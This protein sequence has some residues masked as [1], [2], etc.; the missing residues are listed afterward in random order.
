[1]AL[2]LLLPSLSA[3]QPYAMNARAL[4]SAQGPARADLLCAA[5]ATEA[6]Y[7]PEHAFAGLNDKEVSRH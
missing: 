1:M 2:L 5:R 4:T 7:S 6:T 3:Q